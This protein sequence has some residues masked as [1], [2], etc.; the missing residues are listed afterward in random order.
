MDA[1]CIYCDNQSCIKLSKNPMFHEKSKHIKIK[2]QYIRDVVEKGVVKL[3]FVATDEQVV[4]VLTTL[5]SEVKFEYFK[6][7]LGVVPCKRE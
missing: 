1:T 5:L 7:K 6:N 4:D 3:Q 2:Y